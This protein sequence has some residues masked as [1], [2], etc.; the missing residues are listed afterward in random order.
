M[1]NA[2]RNMLVGETEQY[3]QQSEAILF[4][5]IQVVHI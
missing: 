2:P 1:I 5:G 3:Q 4:A